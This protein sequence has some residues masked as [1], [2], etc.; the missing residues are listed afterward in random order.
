MKKSENSQPS[1][2]NS[3]SSGSNTS[4]QRSS[5]L[6]VQRS[7]IDSGVDSYQI[8]SPLPK[9]PSMQELKCENCGNLYDKSFAIIQGGQQYY[10]DSFECAINV[11]A[12]KCSHCGTRIIGHG[13]EQAGNIFCCA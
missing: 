1:E 4:S 3:K 5:P 10:F 12:P 9:E 2:R 6:F 7:T 13:V 8:P 11:L